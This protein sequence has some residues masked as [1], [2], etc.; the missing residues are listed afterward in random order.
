[1]F[2]P[3]ANAVRGA[4]TT[5]NNTIPN[6]LLCSVLLVFAAA[7]TQSQVLEPD[8]LRLSIRSVDTGSARI[9]WAR[10]E[11]NAVLES[12]DRLSGTTWTQ[13]ATLPVNIGDE[14]SVTVVAGD[15]KRF[16][17]LRALAVTPT[18]TTIAATSPLSGETGVAVTRETVIHFSGP[19]STNASINTSNFFAGFG[20]RR[21]LSR[22]ELSSDR[23]KATLFYLEPLPGS[24]QINVVFDGTGVEDD[25][26]RL[27]DPDDDGIPGGSLVIEFETLNLTPLSAPR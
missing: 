8:P 17:R 18:L 6:Y 5:M 10:T 14:F 11:T 19:L 3:R 22:A 21:I 9:S 26:G 4:T 20:G 2:F 7:T 27:I 25:R 12:S 1:M 13:V 16:F 24:A 23:T 15:S